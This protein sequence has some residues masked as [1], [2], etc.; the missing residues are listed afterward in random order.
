MLCNSKLRMV[1][2]SVG[3]FAEPVR[4]ISAGC[5]SH[6]VTSVRTETECISFGEVRGLEESFGVVSVK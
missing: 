3:A 5:G 4:A 2:I 1:N 6:S